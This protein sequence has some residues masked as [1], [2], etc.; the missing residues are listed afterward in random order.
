MWP[1]HDEPVPLVIDRAA[2]VTPPDDAIREWALDKRVFISSVMAE[3]SNERQAAAEGIRSLGARPILFEAFGGRDADPS[4]AYLGEVEAS[5]IYVGILGRRYGSLLPSRFSATHAE[6]RHAE[7]HGLRIAV[8]CLETQDRE[9]PQQSFLDEVR[10]FHVAPAFR[11]PADLQQ[12]LIER[13][14]DIASEDLSPW[15]KLGQVL[16]R[17]TEVTHGG[18]RIWIK[19]RIRRDKVLRALESTGQDRFGRGDDYLFTWAGRCCNVR[20]VNVRSTTKTMRSTSMRLQLEVV[21][22]ELDPFLDVSYN[23]IAPARLT[24]MALRTALFDEPHPLAGEWL[25]SMAKMPDPLEPLRDTDVPDEIVRSLAEVMV[26]EQLVGSGR[27]ARVTNF[28]LGASVGGRRR[29][30][31]AFEPATGFTGAASSQIVSVSGSVRL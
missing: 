9:G 17:A 23:G 10:T 24:E 29:L 11:S 12:Q 6:F 19:A 31:L 15:V 18:G 26:V 27:A 7:E 3:L 1:Q 30:D 22:S 28:S 4:N 14:K 5:D 25:G 21:D 16:F 2:A 8:W 20:V 13:L